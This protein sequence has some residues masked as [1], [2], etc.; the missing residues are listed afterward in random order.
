MTAKTPTAWRS[1]VGRH[2]LVWASACYLTVAVVSTHGLLRD[3][4]HRLLADNPHDQELFEW[5]L[6]WVAHAV[7]GLHN[8]F[9]SPALN[10]PFGINAMANTSVLLPGLVFTPLTLAAGPGASFA[11]LTTLGPALTGVTTLLTLRRFQAGAGGAF[12]GGL[13]VALAPGLHSQSLGHLHMSLAMA[14]PLILG[15]IV[16]LAIGR[17]EPRRVGLRLGLLASAQLLIGAEWLLITSVAAIGLLIGLSWGAGPRRPD[18]PRLMKGLTAAVATAIPLSAVPLLYQFVGPQHTIGS[19]FNGA[20]YVTDLASF[21]VPSKLLLFSTD[22]SSAHALALPGGITEQTSYLGPLFLGWLLVAAVLLRR[23]RTVRACL[24]AASLV[25]LCGLGP[26]LTIDGRRTSV[27]LPWADLGQLPLLDQALPV[28]MAVVLP[29]LL[30]P[31]VALGVD[32]CLARLPSRLARLGLVATAVTF[33]TLLPRPLATSPAAPAPGIFNA[34]LTASG[35]TL[36]TVPVVDPL[37][38]AP[39]RWEAERQLPH[40]L[41]G[42]FGI[43]PDSAGH[44]LLRPPPSYLSDALR[45]AASDRPPPVDEVKRR[46]VLQELRRLRAC[47]VVALPDPYQDRSVR[48]LTAVLGPPVYAGDAPA[49]TLCSGG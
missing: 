40:P 20:D 12:A 39:L 15:D 27:V 46:G 21:V 1:V 18:L 29:I 5:W 19:P 42:V 17:G 6:A 26:L 36:V 13:L 31:V 37:N 25:V 14:I 48:L 32:R 23:S 4:G 43:I 2:P 8:P 22:A 3:P 7:T 28:R 9:V 41:V 33:V 45:A 10:A 35:G 38:T 16:A 24:V 30:A 11:L 44:A 49:W 47:A 34:R